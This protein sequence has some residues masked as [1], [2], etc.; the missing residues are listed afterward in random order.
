[1]NKIAL[2]HKG[3]TLSCAMLLTLPAT[4]FA[5]GFAIIE[6]SASGLGNAY[7]GGAAAAEDAST[8]FFNPA[9][10]TRLPHRQLI[11]AGHVI[12]PQANFSNNGT[13]SLLPGV[14]VAL[15]GNGGNAGGEAFVPNLYYSMPVNNDLVFGIGINAPFGLKTE[16]DRGW[17][18][19][20]HAI[21]SEL[22]TVNINP[23]IAWKASDQLS[24]GFGVSAQYVEATLSREI[25]TG[26]ACVGLLTVAGDPTPVA[27]C[28]GTF[29]LTPQQSDGFAEIN[30]DD[31]SYGFNFGALYQ[32]NDVTRVGL[33]YRSKVSHE[34]EGD[35]NFTVPAGFSALVGPTQYIDTGAKADVDLPESLSLSIYHDVND[36]LS[37]MG[38]VT[39]TRW[40]RFE[41]LRVRYD[42][43]QADT[44]T[45]EQ[46][47]NSYRVAFG[48][49][50]RV[51]SGL[52]LRAGVAFDEEPIPNDSLR[53]P[54]IPGNDRTW[55][56]VGAQF[57]ASDKMLFDVG[58]AHLRVADTN[59]N[60]SDATAGTLIGSYQNEVD[61]FSAQLT[62]NF[63]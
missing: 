11:A 2:L 55:L 22:K 62:Y 42:S 9:G 44:V 32:L 27:T 46:W 47:D 48:A 12:A 8:I 51:D 41:E 40:D 38:D 45:P 29:G 19:R 3:A 20:Y 13:Q 1:M 24:L 58:Y 34:L 36:K 56:A 59:I 21:E 37:V 25:D 10:L 30:G 28:A 53:T 33:A 26:S 23:T 57:A 31:W 4:S 15:G 60:H 61:I 14:A 39:Y 63:Y 50:Y 49:N 35:A 7:A 16:Y 6:Q 5:A 52:T 17:I 18:G 43:A 54:R